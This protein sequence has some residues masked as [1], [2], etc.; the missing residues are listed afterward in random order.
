MFQLTDVSPEDRA[1]LL[2]LFARSSA[3]TRYDRFMTFAADA[4]DN[5]VDILLA[6]PD[7]LSLTVR[8]GHRIVAVG[9]LFFCGP[10]PAEIALLVEDEFQGRGV[11]RFLAAGLCD[12]AAERGL[13]RLELTL[14]AANTRMARLFRGLADV[15]FGPADAGVLT[16]TLDLIAA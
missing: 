1:D 4:A 12:R 7:S 8:S 16:G 13:T 15:R 3:K 9:S 10:T 2:A 6:D 5:H 11:G 14:F